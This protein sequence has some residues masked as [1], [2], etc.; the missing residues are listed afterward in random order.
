[1]SAVAIVERL[2][3]DNCRLRSRRRWLRSRVRDLEHANRG[4]VRTNEQLLRD[5]QRQAASANRRH[6][7][8]ENMRKDHVLLEERT[9]FYDIWNLWID[10]RLDALQ[11]LVGA[12]PPDNAAKLAGWLDEVY[13]TCN[14]CL[15]ASCVGTHEFRCKEQGCRNTLCDGC[16]PNLSRC[17]FCGGGIEL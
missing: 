17:L 2:E 13:K 14:V 1:M 6:A 15:S 10:E 9:E 11:V 7:V 16:R 4:L 12:M 3:Q 5:N 8:I